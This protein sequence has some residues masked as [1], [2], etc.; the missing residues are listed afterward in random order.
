MRPLGT[1]GRITISLSSVA[2]MVFSVFGEGFSKKC[3]VKKI[4]G[5][6]G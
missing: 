5:M 3:C 2:S 1:R 6:G 4:P